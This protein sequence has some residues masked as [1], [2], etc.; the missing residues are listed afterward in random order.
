MQWNGKE[1]VN[2][3][4]GAGVGDTS[5]KTLSQFQFIRDSAKEADRLAGASGWGSA[6]RFVA[7]VISGDNK[8]NQLEAYVNT[9]KTN[10]LTLATDPNIKKFFGPQ[11]SN[12]D[13]QLMVSA[14]TTLNPKNQTPAQLRAEIK[15]IDDFVNR[16][17]TAVRNGQTQQQTQGQPI[18]AP[19][20]TQIIIV[21]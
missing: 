1:W 8:S 14:G 11:M 3:T 5:D 21:D 13:V 15:R 18:T 9:L 4:G 12:A 17:Q 7:D 6:K 19:D 16:A 20:G 2:P 10:M